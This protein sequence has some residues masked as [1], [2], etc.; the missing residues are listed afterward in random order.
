MTCPMTKKL[1]SVSW[2]IALCVA[3]LGLNAIDPVMD[4]AL[5]LACI[6]LKKNYQLTFRRQT[7]DFILL[8]SSTSFS[9]FVVYLNQTKFENYNYYYHL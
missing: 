5:G 6:T 1:A 3:L 9:I 4:P 7:T 8:Y 2:T